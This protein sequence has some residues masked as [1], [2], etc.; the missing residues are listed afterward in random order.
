VLPAAFVSSDLVSYVG[1]VA[2]AMA[3]GAF[4]SQ[5]RPRSITATE[6]VRR[7][8]TAIG[9]LIGIAVMIGLIL[10]LEFGW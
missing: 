3:I 9:G 8:N 7:R 6:E 4:V 2:A 5:A 1:G 10:L